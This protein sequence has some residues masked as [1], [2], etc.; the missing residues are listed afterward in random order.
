MS[1]EEEEIDKTRITQLFVMDLI[2]RVLRGESP[3]EKEIM[4]VI[5]TKGLDEGEIVMKLIR[6]GVI[7][8]RENE[9]EQEK[10]ARIYSF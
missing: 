4:A 9:N 1:E 7:P 5:N 10:L 3:K 2:R 6:A 8:P